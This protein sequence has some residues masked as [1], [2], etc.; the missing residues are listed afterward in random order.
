MAH[1]LQNLFTITDARSARSSTWDRTGGNMDCVQ[2]KPGET[3]T[4]AEIEGPGCIRHI[5]AT[6]I[7][8]NRLEYRWAVLRMYWDG[9]ETPSVEVPFG[10]FFC[11][12]HCS[13]HPMQSLAVTLN[14]TGEHGLDF[15]YN[16]YLPMPF[17]KGARITLEN[18]GPARLGGIFGAFWWHV[19]YERWTTPPGA[20][21]GRFHAQWRRENLTTAASATPRDKINNPQ[22]GTV[23]TDGRENYVFLEAKGR[24][25]LAGIHLQVDNIGGS[26]YGEGDDM[27]FIDGDTWPPSIH[28]T[29]SEE[30]FGGGACP[31]RAYNTPYAGF[32]MV[33]NPNFDRFNAMYR[34]YINDPVR[35]QKDIRVTI[36]HGHANNY[37]NDYTSVAYWYQNE[38]H[39]AFPALLPV[40]RRIPG[41]PADFQAAMRDS[42]RLAHLIHANRAKLGEE[43]FAALDAQRKEVTQAL[44]HNRFAQAP[45]LVKGVLQALREKG[46]ATE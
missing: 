4:I 14:P 28:G 3:Y 5:Y 43:A 45:G 15:G 36:E 32:H 37:E 9:E 27:I 40:D 1:S 13:P 16:C 33:D 35:F 26:W 11:V 29:G 22:P 6:T 12:A 34:W 42:G 10:D 17:A 39:A 21:A 46:I 38:P 23:N 24:G 41:F 2:I 8:V 31:N 20:D 18:Q 25:H 7:Q 44:I 30:V 19:D